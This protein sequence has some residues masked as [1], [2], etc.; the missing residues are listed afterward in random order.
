MRNR[1]KRRKDA[2]GHITKREEYLQDKKSFEGAGRNKE[3]KE[4]G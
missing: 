3:G 1:T 2:R 4:T